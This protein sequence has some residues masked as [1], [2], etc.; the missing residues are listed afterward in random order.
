[1]N[2]GHPAFSTLERARELVKSKGFTFEQAQA[3]VSRT[4][5]FTTHTPVPAGNDQFPLWQID[6]QLDGFWTE[7]G[8]TREQF[9]ALGDPGGNYNMTVLAL[10]MSDKSNAVSELHGEVSREMWKWLYPD[11]DNPI[12][13]I[14]N[15]IHTC[16]W[17]ARR[18]RRLYDEYLGPGWVRHIDDPETWLPVYDIPDGELW[19]IRKHY[20]RR[21]ATFM[22]ERARSKWITHSQH[23]VQTIASGVL[24]EPNMLTI[25][26]ARRFATY[27]R[28]SLV[29]RDLQ[30]LLRIVNNPYM[31]VQIVF[32]GKAHPHDDPA[33]RLV[34]EL[35]RQI[36]NADGAGRLVFIE[37]Y[38]IAVARQLV[39]GVDIWLNTPRRP[40]EASGTSGMKAALNGALNF[41]ILDGW[42]REAYN[43][44]NGWAIGDDRPTGAEDRDADDSASLYSILENEI[45]PLYYNTD[46][47]G[48]PHQWIQM[49]KES[50][51]T[52]APRF[53]TTRMVKQYV[54]QMYAPLIDG[55]GSD[56][57]PAAAPAA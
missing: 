46:E 45:V 51:A 27:K 28:A 8:L 55:M 12:R 30:R 4:T 34:Q 1:M 2:E 16:T 43:G 40:Y 39:Q 35:Y 56:S 49:V 10:R 9:I 32:A 50:I 47:N 54:E 57:P 19:A 24:L 23:P 5:V 17:L 13:H 3:E 41:S 38:D 6:K 21:L 20:K 29:M 11:G 18:M 15:G 25:G 22:R 33:K 14:T 26:F 42:W 48:I 52:V 37:D 36:K 53:S 31:P 7:L 44:K